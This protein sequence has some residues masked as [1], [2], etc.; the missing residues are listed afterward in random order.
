MKCPHCGAAIKGSR[1]VGASYWRPFVCL[2]CAQAS[3]VVRPAGQGALLTMLAVFSGLA[4]SRLLAFPYFL[5][6]VCAVLIV[7]WLLDAMLLERTA[8]L[9]PVLPRMPP[10][11]A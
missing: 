10:N 5:F 2:E 9:T 8:R 3:R 6:V 4:A 1:L 7:I 11:A